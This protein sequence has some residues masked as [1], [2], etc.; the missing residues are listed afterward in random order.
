MKK[1][2]IG[3]LICLLVVLAYF[4]LFRG[5]TIGSFQVLSLEQISDANDRLT[6]E[7]E[8]TKVL[9][10][11]QYTAKTD[12]LNLSI[13]NMLQ[14][15]EEY[16]DAASVSTE[17][18]IKAATQQE[19]Y[20]VEFLWTKL[21]RHATAEGVYL[22]YTISSAGTGEADVNN[23]DFTVSG[24]YIPI[25]N[26]L[27]AIEEDSDLGFRIRNFKMVPGGE[28]K[29]ATFQVTDVRVKTENADSYSGS[30]TES[31]PTSSSAQASSNQT[32]TSST[33]TNT[34][35][36]ENTANSENTGT[37]STNTEASGSATTDNVNVN[38]MVN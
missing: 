32:E 37:E 8:N 13:N 4:A 17:S 27:K 38:N 3:V 29:Q 6:K 7:I 31:I 30:G 28:N 5:I 34:E 19:T 14:S 1:I 26:F 23:I 9:M 11:N 12:E 2:L 22:Q 21:G 16:L 20:T 36:T 18:E 25:I 10:Y 15:E 33:N 35:N 24:D